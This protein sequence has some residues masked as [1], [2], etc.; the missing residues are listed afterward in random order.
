MGY[1]L[2]V[3]QAVLYGEGLKREAFGAQGSGLL[4]KA[5]WEMCQALGKEMVLESKT[6][7]PTRE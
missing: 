6:W 1:R 4:E 2:E 7:N 5:E 3:G